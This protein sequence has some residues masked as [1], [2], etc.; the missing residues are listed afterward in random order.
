MA[1]FN[2]KNDGIALPSLDEQ[3]DIVFKLATEEAIKTLDDNLQAPVVASD[4]EFDE[5]V[6]SDKH[7][8]LKEDGWEAPEKEIVCY[9]LDQLKSYDSQFTGK[10]IAQILGVGDRRL[11]EYKQGKHKFPYDTWRK[12]L[13]ITGRVPQHIEKVLVRFK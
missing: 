2:F 8:L 13:V 12:L 5:S 9:Y 6:Y 10:Y 7:F 4:I 1:E 3:R 11:R